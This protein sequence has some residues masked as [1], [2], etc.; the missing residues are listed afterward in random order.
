MADYSRLHLHLNK[1][2]HITEQDTIKLYHFSKPHTLKKKEHLFIAGQMCKY[3][4]FVQQGCLRYYRIDEKGD[5][6]IIYFA[7]EEWWIGDLSSFYSGQPSGFNLCAMEPTELYLYTKESF[8]SAR[9]EIQP[10]D[11]YVKI[12][13]A[14]ATDARVETMM[15]QRYDSAEAR[16][17]KLLNG[18]PDIFQRVPQHYIASYLGIQPQSL[19]RIRKNLSNRKAG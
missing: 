17:L 5:E 16:Y 10:F 1:T 15:S 11:Q 9:K 19:S 4:G 14:K 8:E 2:V 13:H 6:H 12:K 7:V 3:V 18:F